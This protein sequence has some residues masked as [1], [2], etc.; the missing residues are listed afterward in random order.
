MIKKRGRKS[1]R[2]N[3]EKFEKLY[4]N[5][6]VSATDLA[7]IFKVTESTIYNWAY[8]FKQEDESII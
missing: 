3:K 5:D 8:Q 6:E 1:V 4:Y 7:K 2:P